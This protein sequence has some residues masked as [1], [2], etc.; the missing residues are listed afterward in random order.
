MWYTKGELDEP[1]G[2]YVI[3]ESISRDTLYLTEDELK[4]RVLGEGSVVGVHLT[5][6]HLIF[7]R[8]FPEITK[9]L[10]L[11]KDDA[12]GMYMPEL[13]VWITL[14]FTGYFDNKFNF[15]FGMGTFSI[16]VNELFLGRYLFDF[17]HVSVV[18]KLRES[19]M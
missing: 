18:S 8:L 9:L 10:S 16:S 12:I 6:G 13:G 17:V 1:S 11:V 15:R 14:L 2:K 7:D 19:L 5:N 4:E 3:K